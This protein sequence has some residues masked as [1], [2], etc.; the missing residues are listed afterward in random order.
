LPG[1]I[2]RLRFKLIFFADLRLFLFF[3]SIRDG[4][5]FK[6]FRSFF[7]FL[8]PYTS[9]QYSQGTEKLPNLWIS[10]TFLISIFYNQFISISRKRIN[11]IHNLLII[12]R[13]NIKKCAI[14]TELPPLLLIYTFYNIFIRRLFLLREEKNFIKR[15]KK[16]RREE[17]KRKEKRRR[18]RVNEKI[19][20]L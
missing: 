9:H 15:R 6:M 19:Q 4:L 16:K 2:C 1:I 3:E 5:L 7:C 10:L 8:T 17:K 12:K 13:M 18:E 14:S 20:G 11:F